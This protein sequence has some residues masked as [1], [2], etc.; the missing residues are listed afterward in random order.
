MKDQGGM[1]FL[2]RFLLDLGLKAQP[3]QIW[4]GKEYEAKTDA[5][6]EHPYIAQ[7]DD[8]PVVLVTWNDAAQYCNWLSLKDGL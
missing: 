8:H 7:T 4:N 3:G 6:W 1:T 2:P 5:T